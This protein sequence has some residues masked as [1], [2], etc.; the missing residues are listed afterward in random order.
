[1]QSIEA[2]EGS[3]KF[4]HLMNQMI[5]EFTHEHPMS[6]EQ[7]VFCLGYMTGRAI[8]HIDGRNERRMTKNAVEVNIERGIE[9]TVKKNGNSSLILPE[10]MLQ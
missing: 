4:M 7:I 3:K 6:V 2:D 8:G 10:G 1:M 5:M 9:Q